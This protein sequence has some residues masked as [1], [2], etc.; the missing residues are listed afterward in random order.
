M[1]QKKMYMVKACIS[2]MWKNKGHRRLIMGPYFK[3]FPY[4]EPMSKLS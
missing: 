2:Y 3:L 4:A 1:F